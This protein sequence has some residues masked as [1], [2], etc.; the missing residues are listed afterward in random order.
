MHKYASTVNTDK[1]VYVT[2][3]IVAILTS[4]LLGELSKYVGFRVPWW[5]SIPTPL[6]LFGVIHWIFDGYAWRWRV[7]TTTLSGTPDLR[8]RWEGTFSTDFTEPH[9]S[10]ATTNTDKTTIRV[11]IDQRWHSISIRAETSH[12]WS[13]SITATITTEAPIVVRY[14]YR[15]TPRNE[16]VN[17]M[18]MHTGTCELRYVDADTCEGDYYTDRNRRTTGSMNLKRVRSREE[19]GA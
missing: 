13:E 2:I 19:I 14:T 8:G 18:T 10:P 1:F 5:I 16:S 15:N 6:A 11:A 12:S 4:Y 7:G 3:S 9:V 17:T